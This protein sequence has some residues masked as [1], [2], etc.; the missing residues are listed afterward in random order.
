MGIQGVCEADCGHFTFAVNMFFT[1]I[2][3][4]KYYNKIMFQNL[5]HELKLL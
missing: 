3:F 5:K 2:C 4:Y 1:K